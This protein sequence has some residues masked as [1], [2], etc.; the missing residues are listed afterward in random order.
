MHIEIVA[1]NLQFPEGP[2]AMADGSVLFVE[3][4]RGTL[5]RL[6]VE[7]AVSVVAELGGGPNGAALGPDGHVYVC[8]NGGFEWHEFDGVVIPGHAPAA[9]A[10]GSIQ[11]VDLNTG[12]VVTLYTHCDGRPLKGPNDLV[13]DRHGGFWFSDHGKTTAEHRDQGALYY[14]AADGSRISR[15]RDGLLGPNGVG[16]SEDESILYFA[17]TPTGRLWAIDLLGPGEAAPPPAPWLSGRLIATL[18][19]YQLLDS[20]KLEAD[21]CVLVGTLVEGGLTRFTPEG[22]TTHIAFPDIGITNLTFGGQDRRTLWAT[23]SSTGRLY[24]VAWPKAGLPLT[25]EA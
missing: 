21:G 23:G 9:Y 17:E 19:G 18:P 5:S 6:S 15:V 20:L 24:R 13:F 3:I 12:G 16:L 11:K 7:G 25:F 10:G 22:Q 1:E 4:R 8:N 2:I 14:A